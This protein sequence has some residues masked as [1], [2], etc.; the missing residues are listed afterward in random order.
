MRK[1]GAELGVR[2]PQ[3]LLRIHLH[4]T[5]DIHQ[6]EQQVAQFVFDRILRLALQS[7]RELAPFLI[8]LLQNPVQVL[9]VEAHVRGF[10]RDL[11]RFHQRRH[12]PRH[13]IEQPFGLV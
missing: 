6:N 5:R 2:S 1:T 10:G 12:S 11:L 8:Q 3:R 13:G 9:P 4:E 7:A